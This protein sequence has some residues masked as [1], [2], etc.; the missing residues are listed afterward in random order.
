MGDGGGDFGMMIPCTAMTDP[1]PLLLMED[2]STPNQMLIFNAQK[3][4][5][6]ARPPDR[7]YSRNLRIE[8]PLGN[9]PHT[10]PG[11]A[12]DRNPV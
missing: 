8:R 1:P 4:G 5:G 3:D 6:V 11:W 2:P 9:P 7:V 10:I 12:G